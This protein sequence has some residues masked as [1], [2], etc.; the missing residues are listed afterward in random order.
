MA[1]SVQVDPNILQRLSGQLQQGEQNLQSS[2]QSMP[3]SPDAG[4]S[5]AALAGALS[6]IAKGIVG[7]NEIMAD[8]A[9]NVVQSQGH[10][11]ETD[12]N[13]ADSLQHG[14]PHS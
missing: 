10:Y 2:A 1:N 5:T 14:V 8:T 11:R 12:Q 13:N 6:E 4:F 7:L 9:D 3:K